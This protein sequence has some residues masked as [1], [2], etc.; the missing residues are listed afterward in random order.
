MHGSPSEIG[1]TTY[2]PADERRRE[3]LLALG[4]GWL[5]V[6]A[7][8]AD[9][10]ADGHH[11]PG[12]YRAG[13]Y[14]RVTSEVRGERFHIESLV[15]LPNWLPLRF[16]LDGDSEWFS[17]DRAKLLDYHHTLDLDHGIAHRELRFA[18]AL[19]RRTRI[20]E[21]RL[22][23]MAE[24]QLAALRFEICPEDWEGQLEIR[25]ALDGA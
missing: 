1:F 5:L 3:A 21:E 23:S 9:A 19:G 6:R 10:V 13:C 11:Y 8:A 14:D 2:D 7:C 12:T 18:D 20:R 24:P 22:V 17:L 4:N 16:R 25:S 15:N